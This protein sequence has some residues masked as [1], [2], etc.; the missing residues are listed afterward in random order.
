[1]SHKP[2]F[3]VSSFVDDLIPQHIRTNYPDLIEFIK[4]YALYLE[5]ENSAGFYL[6]QLDHQ[7]DIDLIE[8]VLLTELQNELG[9]TIPTTWKPILHEGELVEVDPRLFYK[10]LI[11]FYRSR[12]TPESIVKFFE[13]IHG[14]A[15]EIYYPWSDILAPSDGKWEDITDAVLADPSNYNPR[16]TWTI[17]S[18]T[19]TIDFLDNNGVASGAE[20]DLIF[21]NGNYD[22]DVLQYTDGSI[23][24]SGILPI[25]TVVQLYKRGNWTTTD[26]M[27]DELKYLQDSYFYQKFSYVL[28]TGVDVADWKDSFNRLVHPSGFI[29]FGELYVFIT[30]LDKGMPH[31]QPGV[32][33]GGL[34]FLIFIPITDYGSSIWVKQDNIIEKELMYDDDVLTRIGA[35]DHFEN[36]KFWNWRY[37]RDYREFTIQDVINKD[38]N[39]HFGAQIT[40]T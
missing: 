22:S 35:Y 27:A 14:D 4:V 19:D 2:T 15:V 30:L 21:V 38:I 11:E 24:F 34:P 20:D 29:F 39:I 40:I 7:R 26:G 16:N 8:D 37:I 5:R 23:K 12:G 32:Q 6:N 13:I 1:V 3:N 28:K 33:Q 18:A 9:V 31:I 10:H 36:T 25:G 17:L